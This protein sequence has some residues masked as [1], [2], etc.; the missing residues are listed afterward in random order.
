[1]KDPGLYDRLYKKGA[2]YRN[3]N[4]GNRTGEDSVFGS[5]VEHGSHL[6]TKYSNWV[7]GYAG[8]CILLLKYLDGISPPSSGAK[9]GLIERNPCMISVIYTWAPPSDNNNS[10]Q[11]VEQMCSWCGVEPDDRIAITEQNLYSMELAKGCKDSGCVQA[12]ACREGVKKAIA[13][14]TSKG[15]HLD[16]SDNLGKVDSK[17]IQKIKSGD[18]ISVV[19]G[20][21]NS[22][23]IGTTVVVN[24]MGNDD[25]KYTNGNGVFSGSSWGEPNKKNDISPADYFVNPS[26][27]GDGLY[28][29][30]H[31]KQK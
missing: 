21:S 7:N 31:I 12:S 18:A 9:Y 27:H 11:Y 2:G 16:T 25:S 26:V 29:G 30:T 10:A 8:N 22:S 24:P 1:M 4:P 20:G 5:G 23:G 19:S 6:W 14:Y 17:I 28:V 15:G 3:C 13:Y